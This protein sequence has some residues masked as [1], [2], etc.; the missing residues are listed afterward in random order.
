MRYH[1]EMGQLLVRNVPEEA[2]AALKKRA[3][4]NGRSVEAEHRQLIENLV[5]RPVAGWLAE[6][7]R[8]R[9]VTRGRGGP[10]AVEILREVR[11]SR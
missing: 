6:A 4:I 3:E 10:T 9:E 8:L 2:I 7:D 5:E 1:R 11:G